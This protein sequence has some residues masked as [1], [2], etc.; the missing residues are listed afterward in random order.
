MRTTLTVDDD[1]ATALKREVRK[2][3]GRT[4]KDTGYAC[5][6][7]SSAKLLPLFDLRLRASVELADGMGCESK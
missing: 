5:D 3:R 2:C 1:G 4:F 6:T 7:T